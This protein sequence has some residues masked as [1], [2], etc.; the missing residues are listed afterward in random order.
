MRRIIG[1]V[2]LVVGV[3]LILQG[4]TLPGDMHHRVKYFMPG[5]PKY[6]STYCYI[7]GGLLIFCGLLAMLWPR[8][9]Y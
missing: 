2:C 8:R 1:L 6:P 4:Q 5:L 3:L 9:K 7:G